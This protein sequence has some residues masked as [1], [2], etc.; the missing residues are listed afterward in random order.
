LLWYIRWFWFIGRTSN[1]RATAGIGI[2]DAVIRRDRQAVHTVYHNTRNQSS[3][4]QEEDNMQVGDVNEV[5]WTVE[6]RHLA[7]AIGSGAAEVFSTPMLV[8]LCEE[9]A[10]GVVDPGLPA[11]QQTVGTRVDVRHLGA[12]P[13]GMRVTARAKLREIN[14]RRLRFWVEVSDE[15]EK[16]GECDHERAIIDTARFEQRLAEKVARRG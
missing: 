16:V 6:A 12:T 14:G 15:V 3:D 11:G 9:T 10:R 1:E 2:W 7:S 8:A 5:T 4:Q 13:P